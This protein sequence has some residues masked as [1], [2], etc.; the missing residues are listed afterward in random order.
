MNHWQRILSIFTSHQH[1]A[2][3]NKELMLYPVSDDFCPNSD[4]SDFWEVKYFYTPHLLVTSDFL[5]T[6]WSTAKCPKIL[7][8]RWLLDFA[9]Q[10]QRKYERHKL[11]SLIWPG[12]LDIYKGVGWSPPCFSVEYF[13]WGD[14]HLQSSS[15]ILIKDHFSSKEHVITTKG[16][17]WNSKLFPSKFCMKQA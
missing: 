13:T 17:W 14:V 4:V 16:Q 15:L 2:N 10:R 3:D 9:P 1:V 11:R 5:I 6:A 8:G 7:F 12:S